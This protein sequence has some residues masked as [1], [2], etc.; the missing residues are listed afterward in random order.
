MLSVFIVLKM[1]NITIFTPNMFLPI[2][3]AEMSQLHFANLASGM[4]RRAEFQNF[5]L[6]LDLISEMLIELNCQH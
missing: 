5:R 4:F 6:L 3:L 2:Q 1:E